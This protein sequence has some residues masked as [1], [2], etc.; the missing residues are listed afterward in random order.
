MM[1]IHSEDLARLKEIAEGQAKGQPPIVGSSLLGSLEAIAI[2][3]PQTFLELIR[4]IEEKEPL[5]PG[6][7]E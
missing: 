1:R 3:Y 7:Y 2:S 4:H 6:P 5:T